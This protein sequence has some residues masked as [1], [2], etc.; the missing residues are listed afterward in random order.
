[1]KLG[2]TTYDVLKYIAMIILP[3][4]G[5]LYFGLAGIWTLPHTEQAVG[6]IT[7]VDTFLGVVL[8]VS[9]KSYT[10]ATDG[11]LTIDKSDPAKDTYS[12]NVSTPLDVLDKKDTMLLKI[13][14]A[15]SITMKTTSP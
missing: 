7:A 2:K 14:P 3:A 9:I 5:T 11:K 12:L 15:E 13:E 8:R 6:T 4:A 10:P 1:M